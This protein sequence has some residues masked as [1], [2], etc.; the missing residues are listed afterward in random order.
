M[1]NDVKERKCMVEEKFN[2]IKQVKIRVKISQKSI[3]IKK[4]EKILIYC[5]W[6][7]QA[8]LDSN[9]T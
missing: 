3:L 6:D 9:L 4:Y 7:E 5:F 1:L 8:I 2:L